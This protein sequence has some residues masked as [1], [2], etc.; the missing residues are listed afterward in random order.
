MEI[1]KVYVNEDLFD[2][3]QTH[4]ETLQPVCIEYRLWK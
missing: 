4:N 3:D 1:F 2:S